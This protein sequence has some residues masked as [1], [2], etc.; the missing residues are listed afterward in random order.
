MHAQWELSRLRDE[1][2]MIYMEAILDVCKL[3]CGGGVLNGD[4]VHCY[5][6]RVYI[7]A[8]NIHLNL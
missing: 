2:V 4:S 5:Q 3:Q 6:S 1:I 8:Q 7:N